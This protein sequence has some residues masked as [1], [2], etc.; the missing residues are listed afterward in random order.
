MECQPSTNGLTNMKKSEITEDLKNSSSAAIQIYASLCLRRYCELKK[1]S[2]IAVTELLGHLD[3]IPESSGLSDWD[4]RGAQ[5][6]LNGRGDPIPENLRL[7]L[8]NDDLYEFS[9]LVDSVVEVGIVDL[10]GASTDL[11]LK[12]LDSVLQVLE[13][14]SVPFP[15]LNK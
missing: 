4:A 12:F 3:S 11:P 6:D 13:R 7:S 10:Y 8:P 1:I 15:A 9:S 2:H 14:N 5:L